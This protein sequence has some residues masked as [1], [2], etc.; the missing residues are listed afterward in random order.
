MADLCDFIRCS[1]LSEIEQVKLDI[2]SAA[3]TCSKFL[4]WLDDSLL[5]CSMIVTK[6]ALCK[7]YRSNLIN[8]TLE[9][10]IT[11][12][13]LYTFLNEICFELEVGD[14]DG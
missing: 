9:L 12:N 13:W 4:K 2:F 6:E 1:E 3:I 11:R 7:T 10:Y 14:S 8:Q 5:D